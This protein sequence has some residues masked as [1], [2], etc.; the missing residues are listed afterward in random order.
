MLWWWDIFKESSSGQRLFCTRVG[1]KTRS[2][3]YQERL[4]KTQKKVGLVAEAHA[5]VSVEEGGERVNLHF[6]PLPTPAIWSY[7]LAPNR[8][9]HLACCLATTTDTESP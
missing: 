4:R 1:L 7:V 9:S 2:P 6:T 3:T 8:A 5:S